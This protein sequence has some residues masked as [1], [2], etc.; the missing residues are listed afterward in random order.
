MVGEVLFK[1]KPMWA[2]WI[3][4]QSDPKYVRQVIPPTA[5]QYV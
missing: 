2:E 3:Y 4:A 1:W 5:F